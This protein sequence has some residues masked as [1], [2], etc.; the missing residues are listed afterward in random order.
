M[1]QTKSD[2]QQPQSSTLPEQMPNP[3]GRQEDCLQINYHPQ[4][5]MNLRNSGGCEAKS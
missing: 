3:E 1:A 5:L 2:A 4:G